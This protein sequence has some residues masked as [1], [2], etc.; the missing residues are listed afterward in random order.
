MLMVSPLP[1]LKLFSVVVGN[2]ILNRRK[3]DKA[4]GGESGA[5]ALHLRLVRVCYGIFTIDC[6]EADLD[7]VYGAS[8]KHHQQSGKFLQEGESGPSS[9]LYG[10]ELGDLERDIKAT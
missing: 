1:V 10:I 2:K 3:S 9:L 8:T 4:E 5:G 7:I 6:L